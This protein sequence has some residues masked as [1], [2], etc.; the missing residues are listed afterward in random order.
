[1]RLTLPRVCSHKL[2]Y[3][4]HTLVYIP[5]MTSTLHLEFKL[6]GFCRQNTQLFINLFRCRAQHSLCTSLYAQFRTVY[7]HL[8]LL[9]WHRGRSFQ[10]TPHP[11]P[12]IRHTNFYVHSTQLLIHLLTPVLPFVEVKGWYTHSTEILIYLFIRKAYNSFYAFLYAQRTTLCTPSFMHSSQL[13]ICNSRPAPRSAVHRECKDI[14]ISTTHYF[15]YT[16]LY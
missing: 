16:Y 11:F 4:Q 2:W 15:L 8:V 6:T 9:T 1:M 10:G 5:Y 13:F 14:S 7:T 3:V 12:C